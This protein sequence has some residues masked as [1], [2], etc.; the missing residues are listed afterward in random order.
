MLFDYHTLQPLH[1][2]ACISPWNYVPVLLCTLPRN[3]CG[4]C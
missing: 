2:T 3:D 1:C 4:N